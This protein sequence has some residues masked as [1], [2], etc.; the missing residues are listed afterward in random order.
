MTAADAPP[1]PHDG[2]PTD[3]VDLL[4][5]AAL[6]LDAHDRFHLSLLP[7]GTE[8]P[9]VNTPQA[10]LRTLATWFE[11]RA[12]LAWIAWNDLQTGHLTTGPR[13]PRA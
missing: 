7:P 4:R 8:L 2:P 10:E 1:L 12:G 5:Q 9:H 13:S 3:V 11:N 6:W